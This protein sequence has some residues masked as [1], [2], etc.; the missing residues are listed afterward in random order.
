MKTR[1]RIIS[2]AAAVA[3]I[4]AA[5][6]VGASA[7]AAFAGG[8]DAIGCSPA[9]THDTITDIYDFSQPLVQEGY[10]TDGP[11]GTL[12]TL[13]KSLDHNNNGWLCYK[14]PPG[15]VNVSQ[16]DYFVNLVDDKIVNS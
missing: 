7:P 5:L 2:A 1:T 9:Y 4:G 12:M 3:S 13:L 15:W 6:A 14:T 8:K 16:K 11:D 10:F